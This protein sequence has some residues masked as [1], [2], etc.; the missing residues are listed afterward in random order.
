M[1]DEYSVKSIREDDQIK[2]EY[3]GARAGICFNK[4]DRIAKEIR[5]QHEQLM[6]KEVSITTIETKI[7]GTSHHEK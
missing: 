2:H 5:G 1:V 4:S 7:T 3:T 6:N